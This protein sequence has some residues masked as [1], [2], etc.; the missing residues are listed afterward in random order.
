MPDEPIQFLVPSLFLAGL[1]LV[2]Q[3]DGLLR[4]SGVWLIVASL[5]LCLPR[6]F[7]GVVFALALFGTVVALAVIYVSRRLQK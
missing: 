5:T 3:K 6:T 4:V 2:L 1:F 7:A